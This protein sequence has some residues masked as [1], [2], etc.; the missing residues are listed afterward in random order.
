MTRTMWVVGLALALAMQPAGAQ[1]LRGRDPRGD[2]LR[3]LQDKISK[4][5]SQLQDVEERI[6]KVESAPGSRPRG[7]AFG[8]G[9]GGRPR[10]EMQS[11]RGFRGFGRPGLRGFGGTGGPPFARR[12]DSM[13]K[14]EEKLDRVIR[15]LEQ[16]RGEMR[17]R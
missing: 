2:E 17:R 6:R 3:K 7:P 10:G 14:V 15:E 9:F 12:A 16:L 5:K 13:R 8:G 1:D 4:L 11:A